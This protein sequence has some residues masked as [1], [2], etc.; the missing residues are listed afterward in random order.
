MVIMNLYIFSSNRG[1][2][3]ME[4]NG[5]VYNKDGTVKNNVYW[6]CEDRQCKPARVG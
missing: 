2:T 6:R 5:F 1:G 3:K 4:L